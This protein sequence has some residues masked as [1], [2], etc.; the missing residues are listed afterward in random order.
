MPKFFL[1]VPVKSDFLVLVGLIKSLSLSLSLFFICILVLLIL[2]FVKRLSFDGFLILISFS[3]F[4]IDLFFLN[5][6]SESKIFFNSTK[7][8]GV[9]SFSYLI[10][11]LIKLV[12]NFVGYNKALPVKKLDIFSFGLLSELNSS[13]II[14]GISLRLNVDFFIELRSKSDFF[15]CFSLFSDSFCIFFKFIINYSDC[16]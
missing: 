11:A 13:F 8:D 6:F 15:F 1:T 12:F 16:H 5:S 14:F 7:L 10:G 4:D 2:L 9:S 3:F